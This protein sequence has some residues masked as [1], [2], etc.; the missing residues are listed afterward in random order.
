MKSPFTAWI[1][2]LFNELTDLDHSV[3]ACDQRISA[4]QREGDVPLVAGRRK[5]QSEGV[6]AL[7]DGLAG[8]PVVVLADT[9]DREIRLKSPDEIL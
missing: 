4:D 9:D 6:Q 8:M 2:I 3:A 1:W 5:I 7:K